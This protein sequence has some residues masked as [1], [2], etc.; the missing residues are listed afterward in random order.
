MALDVGLEE[1][2]YW[3]MTVAQVL[4]KIDSFNRVHKKQL[5]EKAE[6]DWTLANLISIAVG[7]CLSSDVQMPQVEEVY[8]ALFDTEETSKKRQEQATNL[9]VARFMEFAAKHNLKMNLGG[10]NNG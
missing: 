6:M 7:R 5:R 9:S 8:P 4:R 1:E 2:Q 3:E 10:E